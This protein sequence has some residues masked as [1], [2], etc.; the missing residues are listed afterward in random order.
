[1][2][3]IPVSEVSAPSSLPQQ[4]AKM[5]KPAGLSIT[6]RESRKE[7]GI[8]TIPPMREILAMR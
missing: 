7:P 1:V 6:T 3:V 2:A 5:E 8:P 4:A